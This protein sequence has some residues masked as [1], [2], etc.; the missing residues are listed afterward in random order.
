MICVTPWNLFLWFPLRSDEIRLWYPELNAYHSTGRRRNFPWCP[1]WRPSREWSAVYV[2]EYLIYKI[3]ILNLFAENFKKLG[4][5]ISQFCSL[6]TSF[7]RYEIDIKTH[8]NTV[9]II[10]SLL[11]SISFV[12]NDTKCGNTYVKSK[13]YINV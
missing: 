8:V 5:W 13:I 9:F 1:T 4:N 2:S 10:Y 12:W 6:Y 7:Y 11:V 3:I